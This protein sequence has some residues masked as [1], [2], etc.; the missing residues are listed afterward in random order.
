MEK[1]ITILR[2]V[3]E[4]IFEQATPMDECPRNAELYNWLVEE[5]DCLEYQSQFPT[6]CIICDG[7]GCSACDHQREG[8]KE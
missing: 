7:L 1:Y 2:E 3:A 6:I 4:V 5:A 8:E